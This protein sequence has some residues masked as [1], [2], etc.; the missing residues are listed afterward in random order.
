MS[1][2]YRAQ[3]VHTFRTILRP[4]IRVL[5]RA[6]VRFDEFVDL[7]RGIYVETTI[8][9]AMESNKKITTGRITIL[10]GVGRREV[11][12]L[13]ASDAWLQT[14]KATD[15]AALAAVLHRWHTDSSF[16]GPY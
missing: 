1:E 4:L 15:I 11:E 12:R 10:S 5:F 6:G 13:L 7:T 2:T 9:D 16:L 8:R 14:P 3:L